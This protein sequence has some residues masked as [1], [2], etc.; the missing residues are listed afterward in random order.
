ME[1]GQWN[2]GL[3]DDGQWKNSTDYRRS[4]HKC[5]SSF[6]HAVN[7]RCTAW[8]PPTKAAQLELSVKAV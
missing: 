5:A 2:I 8:V 6:K 7:Q 3:T 1:D 4:A